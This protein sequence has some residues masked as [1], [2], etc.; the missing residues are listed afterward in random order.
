[1]EDLHGHHPVHLRLRGLV[2]R[3]HSA[4]ADLLEDF[5]L[6]AEDLTPDERVLRA[7]GASGRRHGTF[8]FTSVS[9]PRAPGICISPSGGRA[10]AENSGRGVTKPACV[11]GSVAMLLSA[12]GGA[13]GPG[14]ASAFSAVL[15][16]AACPEL[17][18]GAMNANFDA[19]ARANGTIRAFVTAAG[20][21]ATVAARVEAEVAEACERIGRDIGV[22]SSAMRPQ[23]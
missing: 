18:G 2:D 20:D 13:T 1:M 10:M 11:L 3:T 21:L 6:A 9:I 15:G 16:N 4:G 23:R 17:Q 22:D 8:G 14:S 7:R 12:C 5:E 19:D